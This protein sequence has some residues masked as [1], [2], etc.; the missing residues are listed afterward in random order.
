MAVYSKCGL[1]P[2]SFPA[3]ILQVSLLSTAFDMP[4]PANSFSSEKHKRTYSFQDMKPQ[5]WRGVYGKQAA[6]Q[7]V[8]THCTV[9]ITAERNHSNCMKRNLFPGRTSLTHS[10]THSLC[11]LHYDISIDYTLITNFMH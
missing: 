6:L 3:K 9:L 10:L 8:S 2:S 4:H 7:C 5:L 11:T 1:S